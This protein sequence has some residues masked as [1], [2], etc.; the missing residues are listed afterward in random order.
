MPAGAIFQAE[1]GLAEIYATNAR[2]PRQLTFSI[3]VGQAGDFQSLLSTPVLARAGEGDR[4]RSIEVDL[5]RYAGE[6]VTLRLESSPAALLRKPRLAWW[7]S[8]RLVT[9][10]GEDEK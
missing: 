2:H 5:T 8:P 10:S 1:V 7:G 9:R 3:S 4:W 6:R